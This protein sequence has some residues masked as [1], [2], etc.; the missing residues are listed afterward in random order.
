MK[1]AVVIPTFNEKE[2]LP[3]ITTQLMAL[4]IPGLQ[5]LIIDDNSPDGTGLIA[6]NLCSQYP[7]RMQ[8]L[9]RS[10]KL[11]LGTAYVT[12]FKMLLKTDMDAIAQMDADF[13]HPPEKL[14]EMVDALAQGDLVIG[15]RYVAGGSLD[16]DWPVWRKGLSRFGNEYSRV[17][18]GA[19]IKDMTAG[20]RLWKR[21]VLEAIPLDEIR[22][23]GYIFQVEMAYVATR[24]GFRIKEIP[25]YFAERK[26]GQSKMNLRIQVEAAL[27]VWQL[28]ARYR[29]LHK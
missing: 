26:F 11:G 15:S 28:R 1:I 25:I 3:L 5:V 19:K 6:D 7:G 2:N 27:R 29:N 17:I 21:Q 10:G 20:F 16:H 13:S 14:V 18:L 22:S 23:N 12:G 4:P 9:H 8:V 24:L